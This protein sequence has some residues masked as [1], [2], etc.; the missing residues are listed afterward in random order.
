MCIVSVT[1]AGHMQ[2]C[3][4]HICHEMNVLQAGSAIESGYLLQLRIDQKYGSVQRDRNEWRGRLAVGGSFEVEWQRRYDLVM[5][6]CDHL[7]NPWN[8]NK[9]VRI[10]RD[11]QEM[12]ASIGKELVDAIETA[13]E[14]D[15]VI[16]PRMFL[17]CVCCSL[18]TWS[19][20]LISEINEQAGP[21][22]T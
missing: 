19:H 10:A 20:T 1:W 17:S 16:R 2:R 15:H 3:C 9:P 22:M 14:Q 8:E 7:T 21:S 6:S 5:R 4:K 18:L 13:A 11:G 12:P